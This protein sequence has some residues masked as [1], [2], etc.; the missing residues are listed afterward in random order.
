[1]LSIPSVLQTQY[2]LYLSKKSVPDPWHPSYSKWLRYYLDFCHK[3]HFESASPRSK[4]KSL[5]AFLKKLEAKKQ[6]PAQQQ[7]AA[8]AIECYY[9]MALSDSKGGAV[10]RK[11]ETPQVAPQKLQ[12]QEE[13]AHKQEPW[14][15]THATLSAEGLIGRVYAG[16]ISYSSTNIQ[17]LPFAL[18]FFPCT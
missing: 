18:P 6:T 11:Y 3:Y 15:A 4:Q 1:M 5:P 14:Q 7:Q 13:T 8:Q 9:E 10:Q 12:V 17:N 16:L 2:T